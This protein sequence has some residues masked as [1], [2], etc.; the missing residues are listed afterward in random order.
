MSAPQI[1]NADDGRGSGGRNA[2]AESG[3]TET[4]DARLTARAIEKGWIRSDR[5]ATHAPKSQLV[6]EIRQ[7]GDMTACEQAMLT[8][9]KLMGSSDQRA[10]G[11]GVRCLVAMEKQNQ[12]DQLAALNAGNDPQMQGAAPAPP[13]AIVS[14]MDASVPSVAAG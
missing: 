10:N 11:I 9:L 14:A 12:I 2:R 6:E 3:L 4:R 5:W 1:V 13:E 8:T 7:R